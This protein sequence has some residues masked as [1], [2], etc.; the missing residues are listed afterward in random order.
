MP[1][2]VAPE[3]KTRVL[4]IRMPIARYDAIKAQATAENRTLNEFAFEKLELGLK[5]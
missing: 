3:R 5:Q 4:S 1:S 2:Y